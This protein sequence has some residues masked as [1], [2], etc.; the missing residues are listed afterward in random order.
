MPGVK[1]VVWSYEN[2]AKALDALFAF[3]NPKIDDE[4]AE[5]IADHVGL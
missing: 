3:S 1:S 2:K 4:L 5:K